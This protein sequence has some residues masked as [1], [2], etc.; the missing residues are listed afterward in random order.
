MMKILKNKWERILFYLIGAALLFF[1]F[2]FLLK[3]S[4]PEASAVFALAFFSF[5]YGNLARFKRFKGLG[6]EA[7]LWEDKQKEAADLIE[8]LKSVVAIYSREIVLQKIKGGR[9]DNDEGW[10]SNFALFDELVSQHR[11]IGQEIDFSDLKEELDTYFLFDLS[12]TQYPSI[13]EKVQ[14]GLNQ[15]SNSIEEELKTQV[16]DQK[17]YFE[18]RNELNKIPHVFSDPFDAAKNGNL[19][20]E[21]LDWAETC[22][23]S[24]HE[25]FD[26][27]IEHDPESIDALSKISE[28]HINRPIQVTPEIIEMSK[29]S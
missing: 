18:S 29:R 5:I 9:F 13:I 2:Q 23:A 22:K 3:P 6:F 25:K 4:V 28:L 24:L 20:K 14:S 19:A 7:E 8:Q 27:T 15:V 11:S 10:E 12:M 17:R 26:V 1:G 21:I 16:V